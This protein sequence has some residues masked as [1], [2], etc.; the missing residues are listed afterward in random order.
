LIA[1]ISINSGVLKL[2]TRAS[3]L[4]A[5]M[6]DPRSVLALARHAEGA[7]FRRVWLSEN[8]V[9]DA[10]SLAG[11]IAATTTLELG[12]AIV[13]VFSRSPALLA[14]TAATISRLGGGR[15]FH[16]GIGAGGKVTVDRWHGVPFTE[17]V[18]TV[19]DTLAIARQ[20]LSGERTD[21]AGASRHSDGFRIAS[22]PAYSARIYIG[23]MGPA[24]QNLAARKADGL[25]LTWLSP[26][27]AADMRPGLDELTRAA[28]RDPAE[29]ELIAR[30]YVAVCDD[31]AA[32][33]EAVR[34]ELVEYLISRPYGRYFAAAGFASEVEAVTTAFAARDRGR[35]VAAVS[36]RLLDEMLVCGRDAAA[37]AAPLRA[38]LDS[39]ADHL[40]IQPV[41]EERHGYPARTI[42]AV[43]EAVA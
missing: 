35:A 20:A 28:G 3:L 6:P 7:G 10:A 22:G 32:A 29:V 12:T 2:P 26:R 25:I 41:P 30:V 21:Y 15:P 16:L 36:D 18:R 5:N 14:M 33:R 38:F 19:E 43:A 40:L 27:I 8:N 13:P 24:M 31:P 34:K 23:G 17:T 11:A 39:G 1:I 42:D 4:L 9:L 37:I